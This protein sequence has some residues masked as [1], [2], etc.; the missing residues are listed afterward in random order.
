MNHTP[1]FSD[2]DFIRLMSQTQGN[3]GAPFLALLFFYSLPA[4]FEMEP[5]M[6]KSIQNVLCGVEQVLWL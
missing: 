6:L 5:I 2:V 3:R 1:V 4:R